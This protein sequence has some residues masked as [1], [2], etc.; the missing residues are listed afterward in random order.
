MTV[1]ATCRVHGISRPTGYK[2]LRR[3]EHL[4]IEGLL[5]QRRQPKQVPHKTPDELVAAIIAVRKQHP[6]WGPKKVRAFLR[7]RRP[8]EPWPAASTVVDILARAG[9]VKPRRR[10]RGRVPRTQPRSHAA[11]PNLLWTMDFKSQFRLADGRSCYPLIV[12]DAYLRM[13][14][15]CIALTSTRGVEAWEA[16]EQVF[17]RFGL[18]ARIRTVN[19]APSAF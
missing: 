19:G 7:I 8:S 10:A 18:P 11:A 14:L 6:M 4:G 1:A 12:V 9:L 13:L 16:L 15:G 3:F 17:D 5:D 2:W